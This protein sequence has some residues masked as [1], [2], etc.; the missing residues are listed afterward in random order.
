MRREA[1]R[2]ATAGEIEA[3]VSAIGSLSRASYLSLNRAVS[4]AFAGNLLTTTHGE[5]GTRESETVTV[6]EKTTF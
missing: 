4:S 6:G 5:F 3:L 1:W 2:I